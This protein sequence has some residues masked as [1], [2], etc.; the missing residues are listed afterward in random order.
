MMAMKKIFI[1]PP[2]IGTLTA[3]VFVPCTAVKSIR[4][5]GVASLCVAGTSK[6]L[7]LRIALLKDIPNRRRQLGAKAGRRQLGAKAGL[8]VPCRA[9]P[10]FRKVGV[11]S[12]CVA[13]TLKKLAL[14]IALLEDI[15][16]MMFLFVER[17]AAMGPEGRLM[18]G[19]LSLVGEHYVL[20][21]KARHFRPAV[22]VR[23][24]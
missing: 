12:L 14:R 18:Q 4:K 19:A 13:G 2:Y 8:F 20:R 6:K 21:T 16:N 9:V 17:L 22:P 3:V 11:V 23:S 24:D 1:L 15:A 5:V 7:A 10:S